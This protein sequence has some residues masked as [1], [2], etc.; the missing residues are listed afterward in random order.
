MKNE[1]IFWGSFRSEFRRQSKLGVRLVLSGVIVAVSIIVVTFVLDRLGLPQP[2]G[3]F[4]FVMMGYMLL[5][6]HEQELKEA[7][8]GK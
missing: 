1:S 6:S 5:S 4:W 2:S 8:S 7:R 3:A